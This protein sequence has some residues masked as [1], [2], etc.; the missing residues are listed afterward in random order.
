[1]FCQIVDIVKNKKKLSIHN[2]GKVQFNP[3]KYYLIKA[4][5]ASSRKLYCSNFYNDLYSTIL[6][7]QK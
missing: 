1:M 6:H 5:G 2:Y 3:E 4:W 7:S